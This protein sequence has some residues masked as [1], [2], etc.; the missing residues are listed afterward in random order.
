[1]DE[2]VNEMMDAVEKDLESLRSEQPALA[3]LQMLSK[4][5]DTVYKQSYQD[6]FVDA[7]GLRAIREWLRLLPD[8]S[9]PSLTMRTSMLQILQKLTP[10]LSIENL[11]ESQVGHA[12]RDIIFHEEETVA[13]KRVANTIGEAWLRSIFGRE[14]RH[15]TTKA[16]L[17]QMRDA[18]AAKRERDL[19]KSQSTKVQPKEETG[20][21]R[22]RVARPVDS[23]LFSVMPIN[24]VDPLNV[25]K[26]EPGSA[27]DRIH[28][29][30]HFA[31]RSG[32]G[33][34][35]SMNKVSIEGR[36]LQ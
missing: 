10:T 36:G 21:H 14:S 13:N 8:N 29:T 1:M 30:V 11:R 26:E 33:G 6:A 7:G 35:K 12:V 32:T 2:L 31:K 22:R 16:T 20:K 17:E 24:R 28:K 19:T 27:A 23:H 9:L 18:V 25:E 34:G 3:K 15:V 4:V 5:E